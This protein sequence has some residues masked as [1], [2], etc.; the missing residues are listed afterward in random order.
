MPNARVATLPPP[1]DTTLPTK[2]VTPARVSVTR[3]FDAPAGRSINLPRK[4]PP[5]EPRGQGRVSD[6]LVE[7][8]ERLGIEEGFG[9]S[10]G[11]IATISD[12]I[13]KSSVRFIHCRHEGG[14]AFAATEAHFANGRP[15]LLLT[16]TGPGLMNALAGISAARWEGAKLIVLS[17]STSAA[18]RGRWA[19]Q[20]TSSYTTPVAGLF[21]AGPLFHYALMMEDPLE[22]PEIAARL[23]AGLARPGGFV[24]HISVPTSVQSMKVARPERPSNIITAPSGCSPDTIDSIARTLSGGSF[25]IWAGFGARGAAGAIR[26]LAEHTGAKVMCSP[27][28]KGVFP[29]RHPL[30]LGVTGLG[31]YGDIEA[32]WARER[33]DY[34]LVLGTRLGEPTSYWQEDLTPSRAFIHVDVDREVPGAAYPSVQTYA[35]CAD[36]LEVVEGLNVAL[37]LIRSE[38]G[39][40]Q[41]VPASAPPV[42]VSQPPSKRLIS[43]VAPPEPHKRSC[44]PPPL[45]GDGARALVQPRALMEAIQRIVVDGSDAT[46][47]TE[48]GNAFAWGNHLLR[49]DQPGRYRVSVGYGAMGHFTAGVV[50]AAIGSGKK[51]IAVVGDGSM[52]MNNE[53]STAVRHRADAVWIV[54]NDGRYGMVEQGMRALGLTPDDTDIPMVD[55]VMLARSMGAGGARVETASELDAALREAM[56][57]KGPFVIDV[58]IDP[59]EP[60][61]WIKRIQALLMQ[62]GRGA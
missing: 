15:S 32:H 35:V 17:G 18:I 10:G 33:P 29:E 9:V 39:E 22:L 53:V 8:L 27:R 34:V 52:L 46:V 6:A 25:V 4:L 48:S 38:S 51:A 3:A 43:L 23:D 56:A 60:G 21:Q 58:Q 30:F 2:V 19:C 14:A 44:P 61:P 50:G 26:R 45:E 31:G 54:M 57:A 55:F 41:R 49:F 11:A 40:I 5:A 13:G 7:V 59:S 1:P 28:A 42:S 12:A 37:S 16:T 62:R 24:A 20:E 36:V 47:M